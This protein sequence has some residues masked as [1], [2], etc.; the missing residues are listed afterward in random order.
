MKATLCYIITT[1]DVI[2]IIFGVFKSH[3]QRKARKYFP[4]FVTSI[5]TLVVS[6][7]AW[8]MLFSIATSI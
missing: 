2:A 5:Y 6:I 4:A 8:L 7:I 3:K 1:I